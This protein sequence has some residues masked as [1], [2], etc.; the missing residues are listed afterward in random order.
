[1][2]EF[3]V[4]DHEAS[5]LPEGNWEMVFADEFDGTELDRS[6]WDYRIRTGPPGRTRVSIWTATAT[7]YSPS[8]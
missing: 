8:F 7:A 2:K 1:M 6:T 4:K 3:A 5:W